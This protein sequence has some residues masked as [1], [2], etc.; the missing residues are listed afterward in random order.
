VA[1]MRRLAARRWVAD[2]ADLRDRMATGLLGYSGEEFV[3][4]APNLCA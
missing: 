3:C 4:N 1:E 2:A